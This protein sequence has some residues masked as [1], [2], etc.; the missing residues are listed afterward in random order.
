MAKKLEP[1]KGAESCSPMTMNTSKSEQEWKDSLTNEQYHILRE[2]GTER[3]FTGQHLYNKKKG[4]YLCAACG[5]DLFE[6]QT[7][8]DS[9]TGWPSFWSPINPDNVEQ[10]H[11][12]RYGVRRI[13]VACSNCGSHLGHVFN[14]GPQPTG[15]RFCINSLALDFQEAS[16]AS[17]CSE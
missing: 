11:D 10:H 17:K 12:T 5:Q 2:K 6:S 9:R 8:F 7:K 15:Q 13:E 4:I 1:I 14:D 16:D 3:P